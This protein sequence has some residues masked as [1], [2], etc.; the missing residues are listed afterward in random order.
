MSDELLE[1]TAWFFTH[2]DCPY[3]EEVVETEGDTR[4]E[5]IS[6]DVCNKDFKGV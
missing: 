4:G 6:C 3:C 5:I 1:A 2:Y